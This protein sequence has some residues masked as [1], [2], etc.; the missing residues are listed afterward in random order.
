[1]TVSDWRIAEI[2]MRRLH[3][4][5]IVPYRLSYRTFDAFEP[6]LVRVFDEDGRTGFGE[7]HISPGS[8]S[9]TRAGGWAFCLERARRLVGR[10]GAEA[11]DALRAQQAS[12]PV[13]ASALMSALET[14]HGHDA[15]QVPERTRLPLLTPT[16]ASIPEEIEAEVEQRLAEGFGTFK[17]K[18]GRDVEADL[19][20]VAAI[21]SAV[22]GRATLRIDANRAYGREDACRFV[23]GLR[24]RSIELFEQPCAAEDWDANAEVARRSCVP[25]MLDE[26]ICTLADIDRAAEIQGVG[27]CKV[28]LKRFGSLTALQVALERIRDAGMQPV[29]GD[30]LSAEPACWMEACV[31][32][33]RIDNAGEFNGF[34]KPKARLFEQPLRFEAGHVVFGGGGT[35]RLDMAC[36]ARHTVESVRFD[37]AF[38]TADR[39]A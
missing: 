30:G 20:R 11:I 38:G 9:E 31:A 4:P 32:R 8:S 37:K 33:G 17:I 26:P 12:S 16:N 27:Y 34:L 15:L 14:L 10:T 35:P 36:V 6:M 5:L 13:A 2:E 28:K 3:L 25:V 18:V 22:D 29:L 1:M 7:G 24:P 39:R 23:A 21:Q 19:V